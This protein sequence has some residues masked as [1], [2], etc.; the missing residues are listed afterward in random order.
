MDEAHNHLA[1]RLAE[2][3]DHIAVMTLRPHCDLM[4]AILTSVAKAVP[5]AKARAL[6]AGLEG[7]EGLVLPSA[8]DLKL[9]KMLP[10]EQIREYSKWSAHLQSFSADI[11]DSVSYEIA[12][13]E[14]FIADICE[15]A[16]APK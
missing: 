3:S 14:Q 2:A 5:T 7:F 16:R 15:E 13:M 4:K 1:K 12:A 8:E 11:K 10:P 9:P 6:K